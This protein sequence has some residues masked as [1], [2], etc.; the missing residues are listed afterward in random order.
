MASTKTSEKALGERLERQ[1]RHQAGQRQLPS[2]SLNP[3][4][5]QTLSEHCPHAPHRLP[6]G[7]VSSPASAALSCP[8]LALPELAP[9]E[10]EA[11]LAHFKP[12]QLGAV[13]LG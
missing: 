5:L 10:L 9:A 6:A 2:T 12:E 1:R 7:Q 13:W 3:H 8:V 4:G 11:E